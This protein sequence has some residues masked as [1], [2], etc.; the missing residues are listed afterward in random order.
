MLGGLSPAH[1]HH[2]NLHT[3][4]CISHT[5]PRWISTQPGSILRMAADI[6]IGAPGTPRTL[7]VTFL[8]SHQHMGT[9]ELS[10]VSG[11]RCGEG[12]GD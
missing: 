12:V 8:S 6:A 10:C 2:P 5:H 3:P 11:C 9:A 7:D 4:S 1:T